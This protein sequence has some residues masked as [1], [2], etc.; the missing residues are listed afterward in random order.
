MIFKI[1]NKGFFVIEKRVKCGIILDKY[2]FDLEVRRGNI[3]LIYK[4][5]FKDVLKIII[6]VSLAV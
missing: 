4:N 3:F 2:V 6:G 1:F 5:K